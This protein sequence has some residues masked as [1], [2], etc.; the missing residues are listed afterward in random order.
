MLR[1]LAKLAILGL[2]VLA[3][4]VMNAAVFAIA[5][6]NVQ[7]PAKQAAAPLTICP[8][9]LEYKIQ[10]KTLID[11]KFNSVYVVSD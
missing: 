9:L 7:E 6:F 10:P 4:A 1:P 2:A 11:C 5:L 3:A 8:H